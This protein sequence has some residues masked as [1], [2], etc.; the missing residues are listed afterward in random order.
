MEYRI[1]YLETPYREMGHIPV[2]K[3]TDGAAIKTASRIAVKR[4]FELWAGRRLIYR[5]GPRPRR[6]PSAKA[7]FTPE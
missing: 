2:L 5:K 1:Y 4:S 3:D 6:H 7:N